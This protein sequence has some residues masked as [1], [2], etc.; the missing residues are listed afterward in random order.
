MG[1]KRSPGGC[2]CCPTCAGLI[3][4]TVNDNCGITHPVPGQSVTITGLDAPFYSGSGTTNSSGVVC[5]SYPS[6]GRYRVA[7]AG[8]CGS[9]STTVA[10]SCGTSDVTLTIAGPTLT[11][12]YTG[13]C[14]MTPGTSCQVTVTGNGLN[15]TVNLTSAGTL[16]G[17][18][19]P[20]LGSYSLAFHDPGGCFADRTDSVSVTGCTGTHTIAASAALYSFIATITGCNGLPLSGATVSVSGAA[21]SGSGTTDSSGHATIA[22]LKAGCTFTMT[23]SKSRFVTASHAET[24]GCGDTAATLGLGAATGYQC[25]CD[26]ADPIARPLTVSDGQGSLTFGVAQAIG[27]DGV[28]DH[29]DSGTTTRCTTKTGASVACVKPGVAGDCGVGYTAN[30]GYYYTIGCGAGG[31]T[32][33]TRWML[34]CPTP[35]GVVHTTATEGTCYQTAGIPDTVGIPP[36]D[37]AACVAAGQSSGGTLVG[38]SVTMSSGGCPQGAITFNF[39]FGFTDSATVNFA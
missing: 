34:G 15:D 14:G 28:T 8:D 6:A 4:V 19:V 39:T 7:T 5:L 36:H 18:C 27:G 22:N 33:L 29:T 31:A 38:E 37:N 25:W 16:A 10:G 32:T 26:C 13:E 2:R 3:C 24:M 21:G 17:L 23:A 20:K 11:V 35:S 12:T 30:I 1:N 9:A